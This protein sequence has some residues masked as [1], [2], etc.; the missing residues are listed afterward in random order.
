RRLATDGGRL[1]IEPY[2][3]GI[4]RSIGGEFCV[5]CNTARHHV[6]TFEIDLR[7]G[8]R[9]GRCQDHVARDASLKSAPQKSVQVCQLSHPQSQAP[10]SLRDSCSTRDVAFYMRAL[11]IGTTN[12]RVHDI[13]RLALERNVKFERRPVKVAVRLDC[14]ARLPG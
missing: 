8:L 4:H 2:V 12:N 9:A 7:M 6:M 5:G 3:Q 10:A 1:P 13:S 11:P 14:T